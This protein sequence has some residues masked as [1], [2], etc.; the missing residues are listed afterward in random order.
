M[1]RIRVRDEIIQDVFN[2]VQGIYAPLD[3]F[4]YSYDFYSVLDKM[5]LSNGRIWSIPIVLDISTNEARGLRNETRVKLVND[6]SGSFAELENIEVY[7][8]DKNE[9]AQKVFGTLDEAHPGVKEVMSMG[10]Y[11]IGGKVGNYRMGKRQ[12]IKYYKSPEETKNIFKKRG[13]EKVVAFQTRNIPHLGHE[14]LQIE[15]L[16]QADGLLIQPVI[17]KKKPYDFD[18]E[19][20]ISAYELLIDKFHGHDRAMLGA[21]PLKMFYAGPREALMHA[22]I[23]KNFGCTHFIVG[24]DHAGVGSYYSPNQAQDIFDRFSKREIGIEILK[25]GE[26]VFDSNK[27]RHC[28]DNECEEADRVR[29]S[30]TKIRD[31][32][33]AKQ[34]PPSYI[35]RPEIF[36]LL[37]NHPNPLI[38]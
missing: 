26:V 19:C 11:L 30:G 37:K 28:F 18:D 14:F 9:M 7:N 12:E 5:R 15:G 24:R 23:R 3:G 36:E 13:W 4:L 27:L 2:I 32:I 8:F 31:M 38:D 34:D 20:I 25:L 16:K 21:L 29:F 17:G 1:K 10:D 6:E 22:L 33:R 35:I